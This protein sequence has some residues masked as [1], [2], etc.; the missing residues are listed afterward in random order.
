MVQFIQV[1]APIIGKLSC[2]LQYRTH[3]FAGIYVYSV[4]DHSK[5]NVGTANNRSCYIQI[6]LLAPG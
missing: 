4:Q 6:L 1:R 5:Y 2:N 3:F